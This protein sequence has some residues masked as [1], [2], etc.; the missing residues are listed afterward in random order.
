M[1]KVKAV[2]RAG[3]PARKRRH[4][5]NIHRPD[6]HGGGIYQDRILEAHPNYNAAPS[7][8]VIEGENNTF[9]V[10]GRDRPAGLKSGYG[11]KGDSHSGRI[12]IVA[13]MQG[14]SAKEE[15]E[16]GQRLYTNPD[17]IL[18]AARIYISQKTDIDD[19]FH[20]KE[21]KVG[22]PKTR[23]A[24]AIKADG[25]RI[26]GREGIKLVT[27]TDKYNS[28]G[29]EI[30]NVSGIDLMAGNIDGE[31]EPI[32]KGKKLA[33][34]LEDLTKLVENLND[35]V[36]N[37]ATNQAKLIG[38]IMTHAHVP[39]VGGPSPNFLIQGPIRLID[40]AKVLSKLAMH[41]VNCGTHKVNFYLPSGKRYINSRYNNTN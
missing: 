35:V 7:E 22:S 33:A 2:I 17:T 19:N 20:I 41:Q 5:E 26:I 38:D 10:M 36:T 15:D 29:I 11:G 28:Q 24:V 12:D 21:G 37:L 4:R 9:V 13:G 40:T 14:T 39:I 25:V 34:A 16:V 8:Q 32:P 27:G 1:A 6:A 30:P 3:V 18:D 31:L 23:S